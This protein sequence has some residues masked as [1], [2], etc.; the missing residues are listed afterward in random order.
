MGVNLT[1][2]VNGRAIELSDL[3]GRKIAIDAFNT[4]YQFLSIIRDKFTGEPLKDSQGHVTSHL[5]GLL[6]RTAR[7]MEAGIE[8]IY[9]F[10]GR[11]PAFKK[12]T[13]EARA[14]IR[15][16]AEEKWKEAVKEGDT[17]AVR[18]YSQQ[19]SKLTDDMIAEG[20][21]L[22]GYMGVPSL[23]A[24]SEGE[25]EAA[26]L[27]NR[28]LA[29]SAGSQDWD[30]LLFGTPR[31][32]KNLTIT[33]RRKIPRKEKYIEI[34][35]EI[36]ELDKALKELG[37]SHEQLIILG[38]LVG[39]DYN[40]GGI[41]G[42]GPKTAL[43]MVKEHGSLKAVLEKVEWNFP[44]PAEEIFDFFIK[45]P[46]ADLEIPREKLNPEKLLELMTEQHDFTKERVEKVIERLQG[47]KINQNQASLG[48]FFR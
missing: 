36:I 8:P 25:A 21:K 6:Y 7:M 1:E 2:L 29:W 30:S 20:R 45:P 24:P 44:T 40:P 11:P 39:T 4:I 3:A 42:V 13:T 18:R 34:K 38:M 16:E 33:G 41:K 9:V 35:P 22:L 5:S 12:S 15:K 31:L 17:A 19:A 23:Q 37:I 26:Y 10:D 14:L 32:V 47:L 28:G 43:K 48:S 27:V 46:A